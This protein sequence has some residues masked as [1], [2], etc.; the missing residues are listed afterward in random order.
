MSYMVDGDGKITFTCQG[1]NCGKTK[2]SRSVKVL[3]KKWCISAVLVTEDSPEFT[4]PGRQ[5]EA[6]EA[7]AARVLE[8]NQALAGHFCSF[9]CAKNSFA[10]ER[11]LAMAKKLRVAVVVYGDCKLV[12]DAENAGGDDDAGDREDAPKPRKGGSRDDDPAPRKEPPAKGLDNPGT[13]PPFTL[14]EGQGGF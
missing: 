4:D 11:V 12:I 1:K 3:P 14:G 10:D 2:E 8:A 9:K 13:P 6:E 7:K 5:Q